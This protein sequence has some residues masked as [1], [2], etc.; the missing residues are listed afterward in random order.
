VTML[1]TSAL[2]YTSSVPIA[3]WYI[4]TTQILSSGTEMGR[5]QFRLVEGNIMFN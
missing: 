5:Y 2:L 1:T 4:Y 3:T